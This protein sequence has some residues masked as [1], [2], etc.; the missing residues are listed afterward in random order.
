MLGTPEL[1]QLYKRFQKEKVIK[2]I[3]EIKKLELEKNNLIQENLGIIVYYSDIKKIDYFLLYNTLEMPKFPI[4]ENLGILQDILTKL[5]ALF[6]RL[7]KINYLIIELKESVEI[8][9]NNTI[10]LKMYSDIIRWFN[11][12]IIGNMC[13][14]YILR[15]GVLGQ[16]QVVRK[17]VKKPGIDWGTTMKVKKDL[18]KR[19]EKILEF[20]PD[21]DGNL[22]GN[23]GEPYF[24]YYTNDE[25]YWFIWDRRIGKHIF[26]TQNFP[27]FNLYTMRF[28]RGDYKSN[29]AS[30]NRLV[31][32][33]REDEYAPL[34]FA[35]R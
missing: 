13:Q 26:N 8:H 31:R 2:E 3:N 25:A 21:D 30:I 33:W 9:Y 12:E 28:I 10:T 15:L 35:K 18:L 16:I 20:E 4:K 11:L 29:K 6:T 17:V 1:Y 5:K 19:G 22:I 34:R 14:G 7:I 32:T 24:I 23:G 27:L